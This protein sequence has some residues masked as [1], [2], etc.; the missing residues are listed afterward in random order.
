MR[1]VAR[2]H[3]DVSGVWGWK[4]TKLNKTIKRSVETPTGSEYIISLEMLGALP[5]VAVREKGRRSGYSIS[6]GGLYVLLAQR[7]AENKRATK[8]RR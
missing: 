3:R 7:E 8:K 2:I 1:N 6:V 4:V 5:Q